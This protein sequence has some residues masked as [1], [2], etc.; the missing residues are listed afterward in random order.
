MKTL[1]L[2]GSPRKNGDTAALV[3]ALRD[4][5]SGEGQELSAFFGNVSP[6][7]D[8]RRCNERAGCAIRDGMDAV[9][10][11]DFDVAVVAS[12]LYM[13]NLTGPL[14]NVASRL[15]PYYAAR[16]FLKA[17]FQLR[18]KTG[19]LLLAGGGDGK[20]DGAIRLAKWI[21]RLLN[22]DFED[23]NM[24]LSM[25]TDAVPAA[26]DEVAL[27]QICGIARRLNGGGT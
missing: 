25:N 20:P 12:P 18:K 16:R 24:A 19:V 2:N 15:Q 14:M 6:C 4:C 22:A 5:L 17:P 7:I 27:A 9:Y 3:G 10:A 26:R 13:S 11:D 21:F 1:I 23:E 8:C